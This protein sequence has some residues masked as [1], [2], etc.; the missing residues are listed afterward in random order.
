MDKETLRQL[1][2]KYRD[3]NGLTFQGISD[4]LKE[5]YGIKDRQSIYGIYKRAKDRELLDCN[6]R[7]NP[8]MV[9]DI[10]TY[11]VFGYNKT[12]ILNMLQDRYDNL[13]S[14]NVITTILN[15]TDTVDSVKR[16]WVFQLVEQINVSM[17]I[18]FIENIL[19]YKGIKPTKNG[20][21]DLV[22]S[23]Y[24]III[25]SNTKNRLVEA[26]RICHNKDVIKQIKEKIDYDISLSELKYRV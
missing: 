1:I 26:Y 7:Y 19:E 12:K 8:E 23:A 5:E 24:A 10:I 14:Y 21:N 17:D 4:K 6:K 25:S 11:Y 3:E 20:L 13:I 9:I 18:D 15:D 16:R 2:I 22:S